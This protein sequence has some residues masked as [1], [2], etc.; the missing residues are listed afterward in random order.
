LA[1]F[2]KKVI[3]DRFFLHEIQLPVAEHLLCSA[4]GNTLYNVAFGQR[5][6]TMRI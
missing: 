3:F 4:T 2:L 5:N 1:P 6:E